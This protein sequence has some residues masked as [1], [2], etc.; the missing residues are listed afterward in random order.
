M[1]VRKSW[2][3]LRNLRILFAAPQVTLVAN[4][5]D[6][7]WMSRIGLDFTA[8]MVDVPFDNVDR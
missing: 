3:K 6:M 5:F 4:I 8:Q 1:V 7:A 2:Q